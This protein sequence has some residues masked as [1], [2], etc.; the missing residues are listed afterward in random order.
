MYTKSFLLQTG[1][2]VANREGLACLG[3]PVDLGMRC[4]E[5]GLRLLTKFKE[6]ISDS[7]NCSVTT[8]E[9]ELFITGWWVLSRDSPLEGRM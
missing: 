4:E 2:A 7:R 1:P 3:Y 6:D 5:L 9:S 8:W